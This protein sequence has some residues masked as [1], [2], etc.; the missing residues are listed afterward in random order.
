MWV[1]FGYV[2]GTA[3][4]PVN[5]LQNVS[6]PPPDGYAVH[7]LFLQQRRANTGYVLIGDEEMDLTTGVGL[8]AVLAIPSDNSLPSATV[9][10]T[11]APNGFN[12]AEVWVDFTANGDKVLVSGVIL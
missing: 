3:G 9:G 2:T 7:S 12:A 11:D 8:K 6:T 4:T 10:V 1:S 5:V